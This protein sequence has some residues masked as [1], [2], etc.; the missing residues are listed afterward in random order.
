MRRILYVLSITLVGNGFA[1]TN[2]CNNNT[3]GEIVPGSSCNYEYWD[4]DDNN[5]YWTSASTNGVCNEG[6]FDD[7]WAWFTAVNTTTTINYSALIGD[8]IVTVFQGACDAAGTP[9]A[10][11]DMTGDGD[12]ETITMTTIPGTVYHIR[13]QNYGTNDDM[14][15][16][17]CVV[18]AA[19]GGSTTA[20]DCSTAVNVCTDLSFSIDPNGYGAINEIPATG[21]FG[22]PRY[23]PVSGD[24]LNP[25]GTTN[26]GCLRSGEY[27]STWMV[28]NVATSGNLQ[29]TMGAG[30][31]QAGYY[32]WIMYPYTGPA[33][34]T[35]I[36]SNTLAP[37]RCNWNGMNSGGTGLVS[38]IPAGGYSSNY[39]PPFAVTAGQR[40]VIVF[41]NYSNSTTTVPLQ[42][43]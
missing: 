28:V 32:D 23:G 19:G 43:L 30:G 7:V 18:G 33:T 5:N 35:A 10:C 8:P 34:C 38:T 9:V 15:G 29:F 6:N 25:W 41:S 4:S 27:N 21:S 42:F 40:Y 17:L 24:P 2:Q 37:V 3:N 39:E 11:A 14:W 13:M 31:A 22:N 36:S 16:D 26:Q 1:Q 12:V 20:S